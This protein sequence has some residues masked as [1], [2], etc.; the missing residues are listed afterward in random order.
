MIVLALVNVSAEEHLPNSPSNSSSP[1]LQSEVEYTIQDGII[2][3]LVSIVTAEGVLNSER[4][5]TR[6]GT[7]ILE[8][9]FNG[10]TKR[11]INSVDYTIFFNAASDYI[12]GLNRHRISLRGSDLT[13]PNYK[14]VFVG[15]TTRTY[16][17][18][19]WD[20][21]ALSATLYAA[22]AG[23]FG[24]PYAGIATLVTIAIP[25]ITTYGSV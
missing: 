19:D 18:S 20:A 24:L 9:I 21:T 1:I 22:F 3:E 4:I 10:E 14:H 25:L 15:E 16:Y 5:V 7:S 17:D 8:I 23:M 12:L 6:D 2:Y 11:Y 13:G